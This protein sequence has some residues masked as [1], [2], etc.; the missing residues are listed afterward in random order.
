MKLNFNTQE[1]TLDK[2]R[3][4]GILNV[5]PDS[6]Y[7][8]GK[9]TKQEDA[10]IQVEKMLKEGADIIDIGA[11]SSRP[12]AKKITPFE[13][14]DRLIEPIEAIKEKFPNIILSIDTFR[15][16]IVL[17]LY[18]RIGKFIVNDIS[19]GEI[20][21]DIYD[22][23][24][25]LKLPY[26]CMH[27]QGTPETMQEKPTYNN[28]VKEQID[29]FKKKLEATKEAGIPNTIID[30]GFGFGKTIEH[31]FNILKNLSQYK[32]L[33]APLLVGISRKSMIYKTLNTN[34]G[35]A[36]N[37]TTALHMAC[38]QAGAKILR[39]HDVKEAKECISLFNQIS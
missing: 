35:K 5:T 20:D 22:V 21:K 12:G 32:T 23:C 16:S 15:C 30:P 39:V 28:I 34:A 9:F 36:L 11:F 29:F 4:M 8:G 13:E 3:V 6:F 18:D 1:L 14:F 17:K 2:P 25:S 27:M 24:G 26:I 19:G 33:E 10:L 31:N 7:D 37:G 38:L